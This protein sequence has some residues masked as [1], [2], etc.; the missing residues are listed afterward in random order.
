MIL[1][2]IGGPYDGTDVI[3]DCW[4]RAPHM[5]LRPD[6]KC[7]VWTCDDGCHFVV[8]KALYIR[9]EDGSGRFEYGG[10]TPVRMGRK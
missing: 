3:V 9:R 5:D 7:S 2:L 4:P 10:P 6:P 1:T 8:G